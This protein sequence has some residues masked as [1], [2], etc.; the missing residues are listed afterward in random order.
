VKRSPLKRKVSA[1]SIIPPEV[2][3]E[4]QVRSGGWCEIDHP[5]CDGNAR[6]MHHVLLRAQGGK[7]EAANLLHVCSQGH[8]FIHANPALAYEQGWLQRSG[9]TH[10]HD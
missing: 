4:V 6:H 9:V 7:H 8:A 5:L 1:K 10:A 2:R 3:E